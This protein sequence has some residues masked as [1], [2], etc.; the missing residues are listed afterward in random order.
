MHTLPSVGR[1]HRT[2]PNSRVMSAESPSDT[3]P[4]AHAEAS[5]GG[6]PRLSRMLSML[7]RILDLH[8]AH[9]NT[10]KIEALEHVKSTRRGSRMPPDEEPACRDCPSQRI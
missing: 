9:R 2:R 8:G 10:P 4:K 6:F 7:G 3:Q 5:K 1:A